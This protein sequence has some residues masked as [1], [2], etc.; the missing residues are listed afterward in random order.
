LDI[1]IEEFENNIWVV[2]TKNG[3]IENLEIDPPNE[4]VRWGSIY[5]AKV[6]RIDAA[7]DAAFMDLEEGVQGILYNK[8][9]RFKDSDGKVK[10]GG[11]KAIGKTLHPGDMIAVQAKSA[12]IAQNN[13]APLE[14][15][16][17]I[18]QLSM[19]ITLQG[20]YLIYTT[21][22]EKN[23]ISS[24]IKGKKTRQR[25]EDMLDT[26]DDVNGLILRFAAA[27][28]QTEILRRESEILKEMWLKITAYFEGKTPE[29]IALGPDS[30]QRV[31]G[32]TAMYPIERI[33]IVT[34]DH[35]E[36]V[37]DWC[38]IFAPDLVT[39]YFTDNGR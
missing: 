38:Q 24:R 27:D 33:E 30:I 17:K 23:S 8:D 11:D 12:Y 5:W 26:I 21:M 28:M 20:R 3:R 2:A 14:L 15:E 29:L 4:I 6:A 31:L 10:K 1:L 9:V 37:E 25:L 7:M 36:Q 39:L 22:G 18:P 32:D 34:M 16:D 19:D 13:D 35:F